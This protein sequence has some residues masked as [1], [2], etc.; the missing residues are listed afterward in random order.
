[1]NRRL[2]AA[3]LLLACG[4]SSLQNLGCASSQT[5][6]AGAPS[7]AT[8]PDL[9][10]SDSSPS[11]TEAAQKA[12]RPNPVPE[13]VAAPKLA[14]TPIPLIPKPAN[15]EAAARLA[16]QDAPKG[17]TTPIQGLATFSL[18]DAHGQIAE[19]CSAGKKDSPKKDNGRFVLLIKQWHTAPGVNTVPKVAGRERDLLKSIPQAENQIAIYRMLENWIGQGLLRHVLVEGCGYGISRGFETRFNGWNLRALEKRAGRADYAAVITHIGLKL[20]AKLGPVLDTICADNDELIK[21]HNLAFSDGRGVAGFLTRLNGASDTDPKARSYL[22]SV[23]DIYRLPPSTT[24]E[25]AVTQLKTEMKDVI[26]RIQRGFE[27]RNKVMLRKILS[28]PARPMA[29]VVGGAHAPDLKARLEK[30]GVPCAV[31]EPNGYRSEDDELINQ[32]LSWQ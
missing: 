13:A 1:M 18:S 27:E 9:S 29:L 28:S 19:T 20:E 17:N 3:F 7:A 16:D 2:S 11:D 31:I 22:S 5:T 10:L 32:L 24:V 25:Q 6:T 23:I 26:G 21:A 15:P 12:L 14:R 4:M 30:E 8:T